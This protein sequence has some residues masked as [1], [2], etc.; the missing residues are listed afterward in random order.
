MKQQTKLQLNI[1][2]NVQRN[3]DH[4]VS[5]EDIVLMQQ[6]AECAEGED[7]NRYDEEIIYPMN[8]EAIKEKVWHKVQAPDMVYRLHNISQLVGGVTVKTI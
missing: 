6:C 7:V 2:K 4:P 8:F 3:L 5:I 1:V